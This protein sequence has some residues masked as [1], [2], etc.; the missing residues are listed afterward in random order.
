M[1]NC[2]ET[3]PPYSSNCFEFFIVQYF[4]FAVRDEHVNIGI[5]LLD[6]GESNPAPPHVQF[7]K[8]WRRVLSLDPNADIELLSSVEAGL[9]DALTDA[10]RD[11]R[12]EMKRF[13]ESWS[14]SLRLSRGEIP[15]SLRSSSGKAILISNLPEG[16]KHLM[17]LFVEDPE[18]NGPN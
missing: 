1:E 10:G 14:T 18:G 2:L 3:N 7:T 5:I 15:A 13:E 9:L 4:P 8:S 16:I 6:C 17:K 11:A 12:E